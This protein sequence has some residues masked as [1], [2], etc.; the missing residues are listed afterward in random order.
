MNIPA[1]HVHIFQEGEEVWY[2]TGNG[3]AKI[4][5]VVSDAVMPNVRIP[6]FI[7]L[8]YPTRA[9]HYKPQGARIVTVQ[10]G[11]HIVALP[12]EAFCRTS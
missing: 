6:S 10:V 12:A 3:H 8:L 4:S 5:K 7:F 1:P 9:T 2:I 11:T